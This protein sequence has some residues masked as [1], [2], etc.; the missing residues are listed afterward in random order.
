MSDELTYFVMRSGC[1]V[2]HKHGEL[3]ALTSRLILAGLA[4]HADRHGVLFVSTRTL[5][6]ELDTSHN[7]TFVAYKLYEQ[8]GVL[9]RTGKRRG[10]GGAIEYRLN[11]DHL[12]PQN[13]LYKPPTD[14][15]TQATSP[16][17][18]SPASDPASDPASCP[19][20]DLS[21]QARNRNR[22]RN[23]TTDTENIEALFEQALA[24][25][26][27][28]RPTQVPLDK[29]KASKRQTYEQACT[30]VLTEYPTAQPASCPDR[31]LALVVC[32]KM[33]PTLPALKVSEATYTALSKHYNSKPPTTA[34]E[35]PL[36]LDQLRNRHSLRENLRKHTK[37]A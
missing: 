4:L 12:T 34:T 27:E 16:Q 25:E 31:D 33:N 24:L 32:H 19:P 30:E 5:A 29:L 3:S 21:T 35:P 14:P 18:S 13:E 10:N 17:T 1:E 2:P 23:T 8:H 15:N 26:L 7:T 11:F 9:V 36:T 22:N 28:Y 6:R 20:T 37:Q